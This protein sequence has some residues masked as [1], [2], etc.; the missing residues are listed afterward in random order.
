M[1]NSK[2]IFLVGLAASGKTT[3]GKALAERMEMPFIDLDEAIVEKTGTSIPEI[4]KQQGEGSF[5]LLEKET[6][7]EIMATQDQYVMATGGGAPC[8]H[9]N[10]DAMKAHGIVVYL[11]VPPDD[12]ALRIMEEGLEKRPVFQSHNP[13]G[14]NEEL[15][16][17]K[18]KRDP[19]YRQADIHLNGHDLTVEKMEESIQSF[20]EKA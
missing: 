16:G 17:M 7:H 14:L 20:T 12:L 3:L 11:E 5:R 9:F 18:G 8:F 1:K 13:L 4:F 15:R 2:C 6:L 19:F 10:M